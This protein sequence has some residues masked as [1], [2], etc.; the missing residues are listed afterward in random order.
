MK[1]SINSFDYFNMPA[2]IGDAGF[3]VIAKSDPV[4]VGTAAFGPYWSRID[5]IEYDTGLILEPE[6]G[7]H[8]LAIPRSSLSK[9]N[10]FLR[11]SIGLID[12][13]YRGTVKFRF[14]YIV[15]PSEITIESGNLIFEINDE[16]IYK[17]GERIGQLLFAK[18]ISPSELSIVGEFRKTERGEGGFGS[19]GNE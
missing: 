18:T 2:K 17:K 15:H 16:K 1:L 3:D 14:G 13:E 9:T 5:Y 12:N 6:Q 11:N 7:Y 4:I 10:L 8:T 19:T